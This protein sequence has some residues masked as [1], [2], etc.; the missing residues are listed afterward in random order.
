MDPKSELARQQ[1]KMEENLAQLGVILCIWPVISESHT[2]EKVI[3][4]LQLHSEAV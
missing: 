1:P 2:I 4:F 3:C